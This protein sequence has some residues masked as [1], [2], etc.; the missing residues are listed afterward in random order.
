MKPTREF[1]I[2]KPPCAECALAAINCARCELIARRM[3][4]EG[5]ARSGRTQSAEYGDWSFGAHRVIRRGRPTA[6]WNKAAA[7]PRVS[8]SH[9]GTKYGRASYSTGA[10]YRRGAA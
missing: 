3:F 6:D 5:Q 9:V 2:R 8:K 7:D 4:R 1:E 10:A